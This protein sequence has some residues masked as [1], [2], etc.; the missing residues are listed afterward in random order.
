MLVRG[1]KGDL[2]LWKWSC[3]EISAPSTWV[4]TTLSGSIWLYSASLLCPLDMKIFA[5]LSKTP[6]GHQWELILGLRALFELVLEASPCSSVWVSPWT[7]AEDTYRFSAPKFS[8]SARLQPELVCWV[9]RAT[10]SRDCSL[11]HFCSTTQSCR[12]GH[13]KLL[14]QHVLHCPG[15]F[16]PRSN[17]EDEPGEAGEMRN[18]C[19]SRFLLFTP[20]PSSILPPSQFALHTCNK[21]A[22]QKQMVTDWSLCL[23]L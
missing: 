14:L 10:G 7:Y 2:F 19:G 20:F 6:W 23:M 1:R 18:S 15:V 21:L 11:Q 9:L 4:L 12:R 22:L 5:D 16:N 3:S 13:R 8:I 17:A